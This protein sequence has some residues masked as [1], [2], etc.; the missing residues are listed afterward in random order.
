MKLQVLILLVLQNFPNLTDQ[1]CINHKVDPRHFYHDNEALDLKILTTERLTH[2]IVSTILKVFAEDVLGYNNVSLVKIQDP[3]LSFEPEVQFSNISSCE[4]KDCSDLDMKLDQRHP[5]PNA[6]VNLETWLPANFQVDDWQ[7]KDLGPLGT[8]GRFGWYMP[9]SFAEDST[10]ILDHWRAFTDPELT[11]LFAPSESD[12]NFI[13]PRLKDGNER[14]FCED[15]VLCEGRGM[16]IPPQCGHQRHGRGGQNSNTA[17]NCALMITDF[18]VNSMF[19]S[20]LYVKRQIE[21]L[22]LLVKIAFVGDHFEEVVEYL[23]NESKDVAQ[24]TKSF[25]LFHYSPSLITNSYNLTTIKFDP[26][27][28][29]WTAP[30]YHANRSVLTNCLYEYNRFA[31]VIWPKLSDG[32]RPFY[33]ALKHIELSPETY[34]EVLSLYAE[35]KSNTIGY[36]NTPELLNDVACKWLTSEDP[37]RLQP[38][39]KRWIEQRTTKKKLKIAGIFPLTGS[40]YKAPE[41]LPVMNMALSDIRKD[42]TILNNYELSSVIVDGQCKSDKVMNGVIEIITNQAYKKSFVGILGPACSDTVEPV[43]GISKH[44]RSVIITYSAEGSFSDREGKETN[45]R[46]FFR[47]IAENKQY[48]CVSIHS[49]LNFP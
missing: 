45:F 7:V 6:M 2:Q 46:Y 15:E 23:S 3:R 32:A 25:L 22:G 37:W 21:E 33:E 49:C 19:Y 12:L 31:K 4:L 24:G 14:F 26:C 42:G 17:R 16:F 41:L 9:E 11:T 5:I 36:N 8:G 1:K 40:K 35:M 44:V 10:D 28:Q 43:L 30:I 34:R 18:P 20:T 38:N 48:K 27:H 39:W 47:T 13:L 29:P